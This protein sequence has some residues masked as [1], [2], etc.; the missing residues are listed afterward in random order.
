M[1]SAKVISGRLCK[2]RRV[3]FLNGPS[4]LWKAKVQPPTPLANGS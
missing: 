2:T 1:R 3:R 4:P